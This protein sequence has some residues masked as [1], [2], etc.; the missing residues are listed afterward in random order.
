MTTRRSVLAGSLATVALS[1]CDWRGPDRDVSEEGLPAVPVDIH[2]H[3][4]NATDVPIP[5]FLEQVLIRDPE[6]PVPGGPSAVRSL[7]GLI[8]DI[9]L[10]A[11]RT[12]TAA[13][14]L[15]DIGERSASR[16]AMAAI[17]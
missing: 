10:A 15:A 2:N 3:I 14:E 1:G 8:V 16:C 17:C 5:G 7:V 12:P 13:Q 9:V 4:F 6:T 11:R